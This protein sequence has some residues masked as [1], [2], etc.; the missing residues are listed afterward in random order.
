MQ[1]L[2]QW[3]AILLNVTACWWLVKLSPVGR[4][5]ETTEF[6]YQTFQMNTNWNRVISYFQLIDKTRILNY[7]IIQSTRTACWQWNICKL[8][9]SNSC[10]SR[11]SHSLTDT[12]GTV[13][14]A[15]WQTNCKQHS[16]WQNSSP[17]VGML[18]A[19][20]YLYRITRPA[21]EL[22]NQNILIPQKFFVRIFK[23]YF[24]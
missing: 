18:M 6:V 14:A 7:I 20:R 10:N 9:Y 13:T 17:S 11:H 3:K 21:Q 24:A 22:T 16:Y 19:V 1:P 15:N 5:R 2:V 23:D 4:L 8:Q 12:V